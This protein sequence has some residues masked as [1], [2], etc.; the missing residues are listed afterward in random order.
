M[1]PRPLEATY[2]E[3]G[4]GEEIDDLSEARCMFQL[5]QNDSDTAPNVSCA[6]LHHL[7]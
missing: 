5:F 2:E 6:A 3:T 1:D 4:F 7:A